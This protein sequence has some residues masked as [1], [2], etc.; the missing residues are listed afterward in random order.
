ARRTDRIKEGDLTIVSAPIDLWHFSAG[1][2]W[3]RKASLMSIGVNYTYGHRDNGFK[4][5]VNFTEPLIQSPLFLIGERNDSAFMNYHAVTL[6]I[7]YT[8]YFA[9]K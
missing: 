8:Y 6:L 3:R 1:F 2:S 7:G 9:L 5:L 4:Q